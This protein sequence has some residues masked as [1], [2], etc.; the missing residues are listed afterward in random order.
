MAAR[1]RVEIPEYEA[2]GGEVTGDLES[3]AEETA[4]ILGQ[5]LAGE[6]A[7][8]RDDLASIRDRVALRVHQGIGLEPFLHAYRVAQAEYWEACS[9][10]AIEEGLPR[11][12]ALALGA[13]LHE[14]MDRITAHAAEGYLREEMRVGRRSG[15]A[16]RDLVEQLIAG[17][18]AGIGRRPEAAR[19]L[20]LDSELLVA[21]ARPE[22][23][24]RPAEEALEALRAAVEN[25]APGGGAWLLALRQGELVAVSSGGSWK[26]TARES[27]VAALEASSGG[28]GD[29][30]RIGLGGPG[31]GAESV[32]RSYRDALLALAWSSRLRPVLAL[33]EL[34]SLQSAI[35]GADLAA[36]QAI[37]ANGASF[38]ALPEPTKAQVAETVR[39]FAAA[40][41]NVSAAASDLGL[42]P[43][44]LR[45]R[46]G[47][48]AA[49]T[50]HDPR[51]FAGLV[52]LI[53]IL[54]AAGRPPTRTDGRSR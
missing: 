28:H 18:T 5:V 24:A 16:I 30:V 1:I 13:R 35:A 21:V 50:D 40:D 44:S 41:L 47:R 46:L 9:Q 8:E 12:T 10:E 26:G 20:D 34:G 52:E 31:R 19:G 11:D 32:A 17:S 48:I 33:T 6:I 54:E 29:D 7:G 15:R 45:Y 14:A 36:R 37:A 25:S 49:Q 23:G 51:T 4:R 39:A 2:A 38:A 3:L 27:L 22:P 53:C 43:N 42:H